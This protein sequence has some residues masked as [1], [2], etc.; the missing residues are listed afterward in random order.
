MT[1][2]TLNT[3][4]EKADVFNELLDWI[5]QIEALTKTIRTRLEEANKTNGD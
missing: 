1:S 5:S 3:S 4:P 2:S